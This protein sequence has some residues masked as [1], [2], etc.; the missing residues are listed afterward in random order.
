MLFPRV[1]ASVARLSSPCAFLCD[2]LFMRLS[3]SLLVLAIAC[4]FVACSS[5]PSARSNTSTTDSLRTEVVR[6]QDEVR[7]LRD[8][9]QFYDDVD[10]GQYYREMRALRDQ[11][12]RMT[13]ELDALRDGGQTLSV[14]TAGELFEPASATLTSA[15]IERL[16][17]V[18]AQLRQAYPD[19][20]VRVEG[21]S[22][23]TPLGESMKERY[24]SN[25]ELSAARASAVVRQLI[26]LSGLPAEQF[27]A[28]GYG[29]TRP[30]ASNETAA[31]RRAN[32]RVRVAVLPVPRDYSRPFETSW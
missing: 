19:R 13:Y 28:V 31:G 26:E 27:A 24:P 21:H 25:W 7:S 20:Q 10:S 8:S 32:R 11:T 12:A 1:V 18:A 14:S 5:L 15:G 29:T 6:L 16:K 4:A 22:D 9:I 3:G 17:P 30:V 2:A 23:D